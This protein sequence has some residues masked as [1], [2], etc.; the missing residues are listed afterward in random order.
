MYWRACVF[1]GLFSA[2]LWAA[3]PIDLDSPFLKKALINGS[4]G[5]IEERQVKK[6]KIVDGSI[7]FEN[8]SGGISLFA[9]K[10][11][12]AVLPLAPDGAGNYQLKD[13]D[14]AIS[15]LASLPQN[16]AVKPEVMDKWKNL[17]KTVASELAR[18]EEELKKAKEKEAQKAAEQEREAI[19]R[20]L[21]NEKK[22]AEEKRRA[23]LENA[24]AWIKDAED[25]WRPRSE[26]ELLDIQKKGWEYV[27]L[28]AGDESRIRESLAFFSQVS[29]KEKNGPFPEL[30]KL[31]EIRP[32][33]NPD[34]LIVWVAA[35]GVIL[36]FFGVLILISS[37]LNGID[38]IRQGR[39]LPGILL[40]VASLGIFFFISMIWRSP[41][42]GGEVVRATLSPVMRKI[43]IIGKNIV[44]PVYFI[45][46]RELHVPKKEFIAS[47]LALVPPSEESAGLFKGRL[48][49]GELWLN[50]D[51]WTWSQP[52]AV[53]GIPFPICFTFS[54]KTPALTTWQQIEPDYVAVGKI[55]IPEFIR[56]AFIDSWKTIIQNGISSSGISR[57]N[58]VEDSQGD[59]LLKIPNAGQ[60][61]KIEEPKVEVVEEV[62]P[63]EVVKPVEEVKPVVVEKEI[64]QKEI[65][66]EALARFA[67]E[68][69]IGAF[70]GKFVLIDGIV[71]EV[72]SGTEY[73]GDVHAGKGY[74]LN[75][76]GGKIKEDEFDVF[77]LKSTPKI[78]CLIKSVRTFVK[79][80]YGD[81]YLGP[82]ANITHES[83]LIKG[84][85]RAKF[86][87]EGRIQELNR[88]NEIEVYG[89]RLDS[90][91]D[92]QC[93][94]PHQKI[95]FPQ[96]LKKIVGDSDF[97]LSAEALYNVVSS[98]SEN[99]TTKEMPSGL[100][101]TYTSSNPTV[102]SI[103]GKKVSILSSGETTITA[104]Q[105]GDETWSRATASQV[106]HVDPAPVKK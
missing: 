82:Q 49:E 52:I 18:K 36:T 34:D 50:K 39:V 64:Y 88:F 87:A 19:A 26:N 77:Y 11:V 20:R 95:V 6:G 33:L 22:A 14:A 89:I 85:Y 51:R 9:L 81:I 79:D 44:S 56:A 60:K 4:T 37:F 92:I 29:S 78:K 106:L 1:L 53:L 100:P 21:E 27:R 80:N 62:K 28:K 43:G 86:M 98:E 59:L 54:G 90:K 83:P 2:S 48:K 45:P 102:A 23:D 71:S 40:I 101:I 24:S 16:L 97:E 94:D 74:G 72:N 38:C 63:V 10:N 91:S 68:G 66:A 47:I 58:V 32:R 55:T 5:T 42:G 69:K 105:A 57:I 67:K 35:G 73:Y 12:V 61:P 76:T 30:S 31:D 7:E 8:L 15:L 103:S 75:A 84:G 96:L 99:S 17:R 104:E 70:L 13:I 46:G 3:G 41:S 93:Y 25:I 65:T